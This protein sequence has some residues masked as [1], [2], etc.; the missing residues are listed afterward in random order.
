MKQ[1]YYWYVQHK[2]AVDTVARCL[3][4]EVE[5]LLPVLDRKIRRAHG[6]AG[7][8]NR[9]VDI[10]IQNDALDTKTSVSL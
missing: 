8:S 3:S 1:H 6:L 7:N 4:I 9:P 2:T 10:T 5:E